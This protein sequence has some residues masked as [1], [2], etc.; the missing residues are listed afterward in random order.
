MAN[1]ALGL[2]EVRGMLGAVLAADAA[3]KAANV[4]LLGN[5]SI[6]GGLTTVELLGDVAAVYAAVEAGVD[7][8]KDM[9]LLISSHVIPR[10]DDQVERMLMKKDE[11][12]NKDSEVDSLEEE[13]NQLEDESTKEEHTENPPEVPEETELEEMKVVDLRSLAYKLNIETLTKKEIK[14]ANKAELI[15]VLV[16]ERM[17]D[18]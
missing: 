15:R 17:E 10:L 8:V 13:E 11:V 14:Y 5:Y 12:S 18:K 1:K 16:K 6:R 2:I 7:S 4:E 9:N 3:L